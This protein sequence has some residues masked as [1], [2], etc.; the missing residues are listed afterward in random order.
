MK[1]AF[2]GTPDLTIPILD[3]LAENGFTPSLV[4]TGPDMP[5]GRKL[6][7]TPP[8]PKVWAEE[9]NIP[10]LQPVKVTAEVIAEIRA[11]GPWDLFIV[12]AYGK[13]L[14]EEIIQMPKFGTINIHYSL[15]PKYRGASPVEA[16][17]L[18]DEKETGVCIQQM[19]YE[20]DAG[21]ILA[22]EKIQI[23]ATDT[24]P[25]L[26]DR[27]NK[28]G[29]KLLIAL[30]PKIEEQLLEPLQQDHSQKTVCKKIK[31]EDGLINLE[32]DP[33]QT[34]WNKYRAYAIWPRTYFF[35]NRDDKP[36]R[37]ILTGAMMHNNVL[38]FTKLLPEGK[39]EITRKEFV[40][41]YGE[42]PY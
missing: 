32:T 7:L 34:I 35:I 22:Q 4:V 17:L 13:I 27:L 29:A 37:V 30:L 12:V 26:R 14:P 9:K 11:Q 2:W 18:S 36:M 40:G 31:K 1:I 25:T 21:D 33:A 16:T 10:V 23:E 15:L 20:L 41:T 42:L 8:A 28:I 19:V 38:T 6:V 24:T 39:K 3:I 5:Q